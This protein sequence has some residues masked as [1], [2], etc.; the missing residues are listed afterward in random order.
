MAAETSS[1][2]SNN[3]KG[4]HPYKF[5]EVNKKY[6]SD[7]A[8]SYENQDQQKAAV[9]LTNDL[10]THK[11]WIG[12]DWI[13]EE[14]NGSGN[15]AAAAAASRSVR[16]LDYACGPGMVS[17][18]FIPY[19]TELLGVDLSAAMADAYNAWAQKHSL[20]PTKMRAIC[21][22][23]TNDDESG[24]TDALLMEAEYFNFDLAAVG[25]GFHHFA[26]PALAAKRLV[27]RLKPGKGV[28]LIIELLRPEDR[29]ADHPAVHTVAH[30]DFTEDKTRDI[31]SQA[32]CVDVRSMPL[33]QISFSHGEHRFTVDVFMARGTRREE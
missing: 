13:E 29:L 12:V 1:S 17:R 18:A 16:V 24:P 33:G 26:D 15:E 10:H 14:N 20:Y 23:L 4:V 27:E 30:L 22:D 7:Y 2:A 9:K 25:L 21:G 6:W 28:L 19:A 3:E 8:A 32:G 5:A 31:I 11:E